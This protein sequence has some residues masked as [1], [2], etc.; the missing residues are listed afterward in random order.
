MFTCGETYINEL[1]VVVQSFTGWSD[2]IDG[3]S[4]GERVGVG[5]GGRPE[6]RRAKAGRPD[7]GLRGAKHGP[8]KLVLG[9]ISAKLLGTFLS[10]PHTLHLIF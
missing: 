6:C 8:E 10:L 1:I 9:A 2:G 3:R 7:G 4:P 5:S